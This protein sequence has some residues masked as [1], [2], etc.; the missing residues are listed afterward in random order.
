MATTN[1]DKWD[2]LEAEVEAEE[3]LEKEA[4]REGN[5]QRYFAEQE[6]KKKVWRADLEAKGENPDDHIHQSGCGCGFADPEALKKMQEKKA[7]GPPE[8]TIEEKNVKKLRAV[9]ATREH[10]KI[11]FGEAKYEHASAVYER[12]ILIINGCY[13]MTDAQM[14]RIQELEL[15]LDLNQAACKL[16][17]GL[18]TDAISNCKMALNI[19]ADNA[20]ALFRW[21]QALIGM[22][23]FDEARATCVRAIKA[24]P[25]NKALRVQLAEVKRLRAEQADKQRKFDRDMQTTLVERA[26]AT[27]NKTDA[28]PADSEVDAA[29]ASVE[30]IELGMPAESE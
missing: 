14:A 20:K 16:K 2:A 1:Y 23:E 21:T 3:K 13:Q 4:K 26:A 22:G 9:E 24:E 7:N 11:L 17:L 12:G 25:N 30:S 6:E 29:I 19:S 5:K 27:A 18:W 10:G 15:L 8:L 28:P